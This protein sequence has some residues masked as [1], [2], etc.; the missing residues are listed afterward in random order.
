MHPDLQLPTSSIP[1]EKDAVQPRLGS[2][3]SL[4]LPRLSQDLFPITS[5]DDLVA[6]L[7]AALLPRSSWALVKG[8][9]LPAGHA[10]P[11]AY[12]AADRK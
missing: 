9:P 11:T 4:Y 6:K 5:Q 2:V 12:D 3:F 1:N 8:E 10:P 7:T